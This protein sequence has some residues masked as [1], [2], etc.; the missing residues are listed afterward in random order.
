MSGREAATRHLN[1][2]LS[3]ALH[4]RLREEVERTGC[5][6]TRIV[7]EA[8]ERY[9]EDA[10]R[11]AVHEAIASYAATAKG[12]TDDLD[13]AL[14][15]AAVEFLR[16]GEAEEGPVVRPVKGTRKIKKRSGSR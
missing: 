1:L 9:L 12:S 16:D 10:R 11:G 15:Q 13:P 6:A 8:I 2:P 14:E 7:R 5:P 3:E 4:Q